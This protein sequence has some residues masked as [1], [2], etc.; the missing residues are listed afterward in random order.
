MLLI[1]SQAVKDKHFHRLLR[2]Y[3]LAFQQSKMKPV[4]QNQAYS[5]IMTSQEGLFT[6]CDL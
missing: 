1:S 4:S 6:G 5:N 2:D 3:S